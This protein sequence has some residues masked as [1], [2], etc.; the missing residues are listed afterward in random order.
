MLI[1]QNEL[2]ELAREWNTHKIRPNHYSASVPGTP[3]EL[4][5]MPELGGM[6]WLLLQLHTEWLY[7]EYKTIVVPWGEG[8]S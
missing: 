5:F 2:M 7:W 3:D 8:G 4:F 1:I 6:C